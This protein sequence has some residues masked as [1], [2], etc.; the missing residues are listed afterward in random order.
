M[1]T[2]KIRCESI[3]VA[4][5]L[6][7]DVSETLPLLESKY[8]IRCC[9]EVMSRILV[10][11]VVAAVAHG[12]DNKRAVAWLGQEALNGSLS[13][14]EKL[15]I[16]H[17]VG[18]QER[19]KLQVEGMWALSWSMG[20]TSNLDFSKDCDSRFVMILPNLKLNQSCVE[21]RQ[22]AK[23]RPL[24]KIIAAC[25]LSYCLHWA[26]RHSALTHMQPPVNLKPYLVVERR[27]ALEWLINPIPWDEI[28]LDT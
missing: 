25:D 28:S 10:M 2:K 14:Q 24:E 5:T 7:V 17:N 8:K 22:K 15:Y 9:D 23:P 6:G 18:Q 26:L 19:F 20:I 27:R 4:K 21:F 3:Q 1:D 13:N 11:N 12:F 16:H